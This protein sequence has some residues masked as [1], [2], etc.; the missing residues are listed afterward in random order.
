MISKKNNS[1]TICQIWFCHCQDVLC[2]RCSIWYTWNL[3][4][5]THHFRKCFC[6]YIHTSHWK[7]C[8]NLRMT[9]NYTTYIP[10]ICFAD[11]ISH[12]MH[13]YFWSFFHTPDSFTIFINNCNFFRCKKS[14]ILSC[15]CNIN[16]TVLFSRNITGERINKTFIIHTFC[17]KKN[18]IYRFR[19]NFQFFHLFTYIFHCLNALPCVFLLS[20]RYN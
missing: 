18:F 15:R 5:I 13:N 8:Q 9:V 1:V 2:S 7:S 3:V 6:L 16:L 10:S 11:I 17:Y 20:F 12:R 19:W 4:E 14:F